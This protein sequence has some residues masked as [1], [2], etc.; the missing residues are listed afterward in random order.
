MRPQCLKAF[1]THRIAGTSFFNIITFKYAYVDIC[2][3]EIVCHGAAFVFFWCA[4]TSCYFH[5]ILFESGHH[6]YL[7]SGD[8]HN[9][10]QT[11]QNNIKTLI[12]ACMRETFTHDDCLG[13]IDYVE[14]FY[15]CGTQ[16]AKHIAPFMQILLT[17]WSIHLYAY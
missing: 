10:I 16:S 12:S 15:I 14:V 6:N 17:S 4:Y 5:C 13:R 2:K 9:I 3:P 11:S 7:Y 8:R 1:T